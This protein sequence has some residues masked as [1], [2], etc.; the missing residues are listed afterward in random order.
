MGPVW[1][2]WAFPMERFCGALGRTNLSTQL[3]WQSLNETITQ[4]AQL[5]QLK[6]MYGLSD[7]L[8]L[9]ARRSNVATGTRYECYD[10]LVFVFPKRKAL[11]PRGVIR[12]RVANFL[13]LALDENSN[14]ILEF[15]NHRQFVMWGKMQEAAA[16]GP[17]DTFRSNA[18]RGSSTRNR[19]DASYVQVCLAILTFLPCRKLTR[20]MLDFSTAHI[21]TVWIDDRFV[22]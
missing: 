16:S 1:C 5:A 13:G 8:N 3:P 22:K 11:L 9:E 10:D 14:D 19:R 21:T 6:H 7:E 15:L 4:V 18:L 12:R 2:Y 20:S 17:G